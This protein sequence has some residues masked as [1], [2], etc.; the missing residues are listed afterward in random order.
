MVRV[1]HLIVVL[2]AF[3]CPDPQSHQKPWRGTTNP[4]EQFAPLSGHAVQA[5]L[6]L[7]SKPTWLEAQGWQVRLLLVR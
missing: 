3:F 6:E 4:E 2:L 7:T 1:T 5:A